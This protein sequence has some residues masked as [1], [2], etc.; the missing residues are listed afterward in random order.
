MEVMF[1]TQKP[2]PL[3]E[4]EAMKKVAEVLKDLEPDS[5]RRILEWASDHFN[6]QIKQLDAGAEKKGHDKGDSSERKDALKDDAK[7]YN[8]VPDFYSA[9]SP[10]TD[11]EKV[12]TISYWKQ[13]YDGASDVDSFNVN[14]ELK[15][16]GHAVGNVTRAFGLLQKSKPQLAVQTRKHGTSQQARKLYRVTGEGKKYIESMI[17]KNSQKDS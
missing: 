12:L 1:M 8:D 11:A 13:V 17:S 7:A 2:D 10:T 5:A 6:I 16:L 14:K 9:V 3:K 4:L 15:D